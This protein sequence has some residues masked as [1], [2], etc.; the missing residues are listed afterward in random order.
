V[1][2]TGRSSYKS[3][4]SRAAGLAESGASH[5]H[6]EKSH[7]INKKQ[8]LNPN[9]KEK[10]WQ[11]FIFVASVFFPCGTNK[12]DTTTCKSTEREREMSIQRER[13]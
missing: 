11:I 12:K 6:A 4:P 13:C 5:S 2:V 3:P 9:H 8:E 10:N 1:T 7:S